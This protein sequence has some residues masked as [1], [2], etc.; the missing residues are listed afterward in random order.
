MKATLHNGTGLV[1]LL[2][3]CY[4]LPEDEREQ[5]EAFAGRPYSAEAL[6]AALFAAPGPKWTVLAGET[7]I[8][9]AGFQELR[10]GVWQDWAVTTPEAWEMHWRSVTKFARRVMDEM[11]LG[12]AH[13]LQCI[14]LASRIHAHRWYRPLGLKLEGPLHAYGANQEDALMFYRLRS[15]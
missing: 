13:R 8:L 3:V 4:R 14:S 15:P 1:E 5:Y 9:V 2:R 7:P 10:A 11:L 6:A 12:P